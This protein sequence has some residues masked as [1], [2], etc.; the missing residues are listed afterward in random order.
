LEKINNQREKKKKK[1][2]CTHVWGRLAN[3][4]CFYLF[5]YLLRGVWHVVR[6]FKPKLNLEKL[7][8]Q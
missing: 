3:E 4:D 8:G 5:I 1:G 7:K 2:S 6:T